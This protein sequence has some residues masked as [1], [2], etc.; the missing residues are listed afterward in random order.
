MIYG[1][2]TRNSNG[3]N[4]VFSLITVSVYTR[5]VE[6]AV[7]LSPPMW[8]AAG[9][10]VHVAIIRIPPPPPPQPSAGYRGRRN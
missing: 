5:E 2:N 9:F 10:P 3:L 7:A 1:A 4:G 6:T 8:A